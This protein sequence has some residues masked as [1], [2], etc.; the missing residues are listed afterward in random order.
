MNINEKQYNLLNKLLKNYRLKKDISTLTQFEASIIIEGIINKGKVKDSYKGKKLSDI[1]YKKK[2]SFFDN[3][4]EIKNPYITE[5]QLRFIKNLIQIS[6]YQLIDVNIR[7]EDANALISFLRDNHYSK[8][9]LKYLKEIDEESLIKVKE[10]Q[11]NKTRVIPEEWILYD[12]K[13]NGI[14]DF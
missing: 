13:I 14:V 9:A 8:T 10:T 4:V 6:K 1:D 11:N 7:R 2:Q 5:K 12:T 3:L